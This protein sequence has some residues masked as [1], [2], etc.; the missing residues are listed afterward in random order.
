MGLFKNK[1]KIFCIGL[2]KTG[3]TTIEQ[4][5]RDLDFSVGVQR[6]AEFLV[7][8]WAK[9]DFKK[10]ITYCNTAKAFQDVP[11]SLPYTYVVLD[12][13]F[14]NSKFVLSIRNSPEEW[15][16]SITK[17]HS[18]K[19]SPNN[20]C[21]PTIEDLKQARYIYTGRPYIMNRL[22]Y[23]TPE[24][25]PYNKDY[26]LAYY[27]R[28]IQEVKDYF[29]HQPEKLCIVNVSVEEDYFRLCEFLG[30]N[31]KTDGFPWLNKT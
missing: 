30:K 12:Q 11:F 16:N 23:T 10:L 13:Y 27:N 25:D 18:K 2:N 14:P 8:D 17:F 31:P 20:N 5:F 21:P 7:D 1:S 4:V 28:H 19:W 24:S 29:R 3:T 9:R 6:I 22:Y 26:F 15:Y